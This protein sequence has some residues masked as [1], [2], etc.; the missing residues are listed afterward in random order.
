MGAP[1][2]IRN[3]SNKRGRMSDRRELEPRAYIACG[4]I[5]GVVCGFF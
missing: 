5:A 3:S 4:F 1:R 2:Q